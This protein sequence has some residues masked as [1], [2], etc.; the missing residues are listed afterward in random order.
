MMMMMMMM[1]FPIFV[2]ADKLENWFIK[3]HENQE[4]KTTSRV[5][6][7][8]GPIGRER[9]SGVSMVRDLWWEEFPKR[10]VLS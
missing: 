4:L 6:T 3:L 1:K 10:Y 2:C 9:Q 7:E 8:S 5:E